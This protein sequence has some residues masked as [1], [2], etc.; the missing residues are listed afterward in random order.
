M[1]QFRLCPRS[2]GPVVLDQFCAKI[3]ADFNCFIRKQKWADQDQI[4]FNGILFEV[5]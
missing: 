5:F 4:Y 2:F 1:N 3:Q